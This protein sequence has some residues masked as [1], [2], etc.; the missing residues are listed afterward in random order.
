MSVNGRFYVTTQCGRTFCV[1]PL[2]ASV[3]HGP[4]VWGDLDPATKTVT[5]N[6]GQKYP[7]ATHPDESIITEGNGF[8][9]IVTLERGV[10]PM[11]YIEMLL[12]Q[13]KK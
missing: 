1:E 4:K 5:G 3:G 2:D 12:A 10:S 8:K 13:N 7:G 11:G 6:Y 9:N